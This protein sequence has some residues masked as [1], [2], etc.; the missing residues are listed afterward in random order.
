MRWYWDHVLSFSPL[1]ALRSVKVP[2][3]GVF[4]EVDVSTQAS[5]AAENLRRTLIE[6]GNDD[7]TVKIFPG[8]DH[9]LSVESGARM[10]PGVFDTLRSWLLARVEAP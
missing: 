8:A 9:S 3:L 10:A 6:A 7:V 1:P 4:G 2:V 5:V